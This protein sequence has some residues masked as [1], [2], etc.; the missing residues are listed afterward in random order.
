MNLFFVP[1]QLRTRLNSYFY[2][3]LS[4]AHHKSFF[5]LML[6]SFYSTQFKV[7]KVE[8]LLC[9]IL[10]KSPLD[11]T[12]CY[13]MSFLP[14]NHTLCYVY[15]FY[16]KKLKNYSFLKIVYTLKFPFVN[17]Y[18]LIHLSKY[19][20]TICNHYSTVMLTTIIPCQMLQNTENKSQ[21]Q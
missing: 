4:Q 9:L 6:I 14:H 17:N 1:L 19:S 5:G 11:K 8:C 13:L 21:L 15:Y 7:I 10:S 18:S 3:F 16:F 2:L 12:V 20:T